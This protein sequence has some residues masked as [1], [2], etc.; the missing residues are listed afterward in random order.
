MLQRIRQTLSALR[1]SYKKLR[2]SAWYKKTNAAVTAFLF[3][4]VAYV[5]VGYVKNQYE[6]D[7]QAHLQYAITK[8]DIKQMRYL[9]ALLEGPEEDL[10]DYELYGDIFTMNHLAFQAYALTNIGLSSPPHRDEA[11]QHV[12]LII[13]KMTA[14]PFRTDFGVYTGDALSEEREIEGNVVYYGHL[15][16]T[17]GAYRLLSGD[18]EYD[19]LHTRITDALARQFEADETHHIDTDPRRQWPAD[20]VPALASVHLY[21]RVHG[22]DHSNAI[23]AWTE[24]TLANMLD[25]NGLL[26]SHISDRTHK[27]DEEARGCALAY[28]IPFIHMFDPSFANQLY[29][30]FRTHFFVTR[31]GMDFPREYITPG[32][33]A[34]AD[35]GP[36]ILG[37]GAVASGFSIGASKIADDEGTFESLSRI[38][39]LTTFPYETWS[40][41]GYLLNV[42]LGETVLLFGRTLRPWHAVEPPAGETTP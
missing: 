31:F 32:H 1:A 25:E 40:H 7:P 16:L 15:N 26:Y 3:G 34:D 37:V 11:A 20:N 18:T 19:T 5:L 23:A 8:S 10:S 17:L 14:E 6:L 2:E 36:I 38:A 35:S 28:S 9:N 29:R 41:K 4:A 30:H 33:A 39:E 12:N 42:T 13:R 27:P 22:T 24:W 21:D